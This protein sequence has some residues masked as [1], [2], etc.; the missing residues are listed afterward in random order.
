[1]KT[2][3]FL[4]VLLIGLVANLALGQ[5]RVTI[6]QALEEAVFNGAAVF[7][8][9]VRLTTAASKLIP[10]ATSFAIRNNADSA[11][12]VL[13]SNAGGVTVRSGLVITDGTLTGASDTGFGWTIGSG[14]NTACNTTCGVSACLVG[15][16]T[17]TG[18]LVACATG[19]ADLC[20]C[21]G[22]TS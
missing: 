10:G 21:A 2:K 8:S 16:D 9:T 13:V 18:A 4:A 17:G 7:G 5:A 3:L 15:Q 12:N 20:V 19:T 1:M 22:P 14:A 6:T 11:N